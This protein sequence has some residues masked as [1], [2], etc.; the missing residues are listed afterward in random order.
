MIYLI[1]FSW[2]VKKL[3]YFIDSIKLTKMEVRQ[4]GKFKICRNGDVERS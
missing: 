4:D 3:N 2:H 1:L